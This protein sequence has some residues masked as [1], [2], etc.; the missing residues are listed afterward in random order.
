MDVDRWPVTHLIALGEVGI[1]VKSPPSVGPSR[2]HELARRCC[3][4]AGAVVEL[5]EDLVVVEQ[6]LPYRDVAISIYVRIPLEFLCN[7]LSANKEKHSSPASR[8]SI[9]QRG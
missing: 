1:E 6:E 3:H 7:F 9:T 8:I 5:E 2:F 4:L